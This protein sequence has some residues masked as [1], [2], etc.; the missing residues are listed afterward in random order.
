MQYT[1]DGKY[2]ATYPHARA[3]AKKMGVQYQTIY[4][5][6]TGESKTSCGYIWKYVD[7]N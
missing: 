6:C 2:V 3:A 4:K 7:K 5:A 1:I